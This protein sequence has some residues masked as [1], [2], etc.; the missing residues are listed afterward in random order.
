MTGADLA[1]SNM[2]DLSE[3]LE[4]VTVE[5]DDDL[6]Q[7]LEGEEEVEASLKKELKEERELKQATKKRS[8]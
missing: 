7:L 2:R 1:L 4:T 3:N 6:H 5:L 8:I